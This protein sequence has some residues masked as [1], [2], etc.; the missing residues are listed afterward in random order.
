MV[1]NVTGWCCGGI[2]CCVLRALIWRTSCRGWHEQQVLRR[3]RSGKV[4]RF[5]YS[6]GFNAMH[7]VCVCMY[8][9]M[10]G[11][12]YGN[13]CLF[14]CLFVCMYV[15]MPTLPHCPFSHLPPLFHLVPLSRPSFLQMQARSAQHAVSA[16]HKEKYWK[17]LRCCLILIFLL[18]SVNSTTRAHNTTNMTSSTTSTWLP[19]KRSTQH[20]VRPQ[21]QP[22]TSPT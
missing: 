4:L 11:C 10:D 21:H 2:A 15:C 19:P 5:Q 16:S 17:V 18:H 13:D 14:V 7:Y 12:S 9:W 1:G 20:A 22:I 6:I 3:S 8:G